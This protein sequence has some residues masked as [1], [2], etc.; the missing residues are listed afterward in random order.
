MTI[1]N[2]NHRQWPAHGALAGE[3]AGPL[4]VAH[5]VVVDECDNRA[6]AVS[7][8]DGK[9][10][11]FELGTLK[12]MSPMVSAC[13]SFSHIRRCN[14]LLPSTQVLATV[15]SSCVMLCSLRQVQLSAKPRHGIFSTLPCL[16]LQLLRAH[17]PLQCLPL[18][19]FWYTHVMFVTQKT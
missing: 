2:S 15:L 8:E 10:L 7:R 4:Q 11:T 18:P 5:G 16:H 12:Y 6:Y 19:A 14:V 17:K 1:D 13:V 3:G 9:V